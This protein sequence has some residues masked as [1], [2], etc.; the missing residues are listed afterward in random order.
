ML[1][2]LS[3][4]KFFEENVL[5]QDSAHLWLETRL[6]VAHKLQR[7]WKNIFAAPKI[8]LLTGVYY[9][10]DA[11]VYTIRSESSSAD[12]RVTVPIP[13]PS[14]ITAMLGVKAG[15]KFKFGREQVI[16]A[17][18]QILGRKV[19]AAQW[20]RVG[21]RYFIKEDAST[22]LS[23]KQLRLLDVWSV[24]T[25]RGDNDPWV[26]ELSLPESGSGDGLEA[27]EEYDEKMWKE[28]ENSVDALLEDLEP[29][30]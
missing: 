19:W 21:A 3:P 4:H 15:M 1:T 16:E 12:A 29:S 14:G 24:G 22:E 2:Q 7:M 26:A 25:E 5:K 13:E 23:P 20:T 6:S 10:E 11:Q 18:A 8:W 27:G 28:F 30:I 17:E 9:M